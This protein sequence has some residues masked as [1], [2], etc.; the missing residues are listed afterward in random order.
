MTKKGKS[1]PVPPS[2][3]SHFEENDSSGPLMADKM[4]MAAAEGKI[5]EFM[6]SALP[7]SEHARKLAS[8]MMG[9][10]GLMPP[11]MQPQNQSTNQPGPVEQ[12]G[13]ESAGALTAP[14]SAAEMP[15]PPGPPPDDVYRAIQDADVNGLM[16]LLKQEHGRRSGEVQNEP[17]PTAVPGNEQLGSLEKE[18]LDR[19]IRISSEQNLS[20]DWIIMRALRLYLG[21]YQK[22]GKL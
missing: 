22:T 10:S 11:M 20:P 6:K 5:E 13:P 15:E 3:R 12:S 8:M 21:E 4:A 7:D 18:L 19:V 17:L 1:L 9:M 2:R 14:A 16:D